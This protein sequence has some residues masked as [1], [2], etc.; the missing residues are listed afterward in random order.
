MDLTL[1]SGNDKILEL[2]FTRNGAVVNITTWKVFF[3]IKT[4]IDREETDLGAVIKKDITIHTAPTLGKT[5]IFLTAAE[6]LALHGNYRFDIQ[7]KD[8]SGHITTVTAGTLVVDERVTK[9]TS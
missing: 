2:T 3:T 4:L 5:Q 7:V 1:T 8:E 9:R 6:T